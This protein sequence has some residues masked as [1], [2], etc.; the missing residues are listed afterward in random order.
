VAHLTWQCTDLERTVRFLSELFGWS[1][2][3]QGDAYFVSATPSGA[4]VGVTKVDAIRHGNAFVPHVS[5]ADLAEVVA[6]ARELGAV[7][8]EE[9]GHITAV[10]RYADIEDPDGSLFTVIEFAGAGA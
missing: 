2:T 9:E 8:V 7:I 6:K 1:S 4:W 10:G 5:V 3:P